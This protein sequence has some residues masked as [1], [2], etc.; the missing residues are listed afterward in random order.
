MRFGMNLLLWSAGFP[1]EALPLLEKVK[2]IGFDGVELPV[3]DLDAVDVPATRQALADNDLGVIVCMIVQEDQNLIS[4]DPAARRRGVDHL[5]RAI[6]LTAALGA[7]VLCGPMYSPVG[8][9]VG[10]GRTEEEW[11]WCVEAYRELGPHAEKAGVRMAL[12]ALNRFETYFLNIAEDVVRLAEEVG[13]PAIGLHYDTFHA[14][15]EEQDPVGA[16]TASAPRLFHFH[17]SENDRGPVGTGHVDW[18]NSFKALKAI[19][20]KGWV[21]VES[22]LPAIKELA[23][24][25]AI[26]RELAPSGDALAQQSIRFLRQFD[27]GVNS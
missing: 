14:N 10:R 21:V 25:A 12:E 4:E 11:R 27:R 23:A 18:E 19:D 7:E 8:R 26:W 1:R 3:F 15:I 13:S 5:K 17:A 20:Y 24:A 16:I 2:G 22:F 6:D 9:L